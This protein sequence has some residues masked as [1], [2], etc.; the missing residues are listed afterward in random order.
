MPEVIDEKEIPE[1]DNTE[2]IEFE[3]QDDTPDE[4][5]DPVTGKE[6]EPMPTNITTIHY[7]INPNSTL[8]YL[9]AFI[10]KKNQRGRNATNFITAL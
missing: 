1:Q 6:R 9:Y 4:D 8:T 10:Y 5:K 2:D 7:L 3:I